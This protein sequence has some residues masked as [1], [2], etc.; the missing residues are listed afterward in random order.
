ME[1]DGEETAIATAGVAQAI[2]EGPI[3]VELRVVD[4]F[5]CKDGSVSSG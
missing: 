2:V 3:R 1:D 5:D 4:L